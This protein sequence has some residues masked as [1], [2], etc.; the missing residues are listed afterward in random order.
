MGSGSGTR[1]R[2]GLRWTSI[3]RR[4][5]WSRFSSAKIATPGAAVTSEPGFFGANAAGSVFAPDANGLDQAGSFARV[6]GGGV[7]EIRRDGIGIG[8]GSSGTVF[9]Q[10]R[11][12]DTVDPDFVVG[13]SEGGNLGFFNS[14]YA[15]KV[16][17]PG[18][19]GRLVLQTAAGT[20]TTSGLLPNVNYNVVAFIDNVADDLDVYIQ[21]DQDASFATPVSVN[22]GAGND[23]YTKTFG[24][25]PTTTPNID[26]IT[27]NNFG[28]TLP[29]V[30]DNLY[31]DTTGLNLT[32]PVAIPEPASVAA[33]IVIGGAV[34]TRR[35]RR[36]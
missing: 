11:L 17:G 23:T 16:R 9:F 15:F 32:N 30:I 13:F 27:F 3:C 26:N 28:T 21:S 33:L 20:G 2:G 7:S 36:L 5:F 12:T 4:L 10:L 8:D 19:D 6:V 1:P 24:A 35:R 18:G 22:P 29:V 31:V 25:N 14:A 34:V